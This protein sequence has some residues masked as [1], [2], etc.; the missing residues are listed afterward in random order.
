MTRVPWV[1]LNSYLI[2]HILFSGF[3]AALCGQLQLT[4]F[5]VF[6]FSDS[7]GRTEGSWLWWSS[8]CK[9]DKWTATE[10]ARRKLP[11]MEQTGIKRAIT[12]KN[13]K[14]NVLVLLY[15]HNGAEPFIQQF[16]MKSGGTFH[17]I[18]A[19]LW[20][21]C[22]WIIIIIFLTEKY[23]Y[24]VVWSSCR[25][26]KQ[27]GKFTDVFVPWSKMRQIQCISRANS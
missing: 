25:K 23:K 6:G 14:G 27:R 12:W 20:R 13:E 21:Y 7:L 5:T 26:R 16:I 2:Y 3:I 8:T 18:Y 24:Y 1:R 19:N 9:S 22:L 10:C 17:V 4:F 11:H 15:I